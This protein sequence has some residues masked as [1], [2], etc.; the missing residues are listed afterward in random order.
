MRKNTISTYQN[1]AVIRTKNTRI[2]IQESE[3]AVVLDFIRT[4]KEGESPDTLSAL[5]EV[6][7]NRRVTRFK[8][9]PQAM[10]LLCAAYSRYKFDQQKGVFTEITLKP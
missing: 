2:V 3:E 7:K 1:G 9:T 10:G 6:N 8:L 5:Q 4:L